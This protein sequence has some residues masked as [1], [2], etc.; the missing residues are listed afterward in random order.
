[1]FQF[2]HLF[3]IQRDNLGREHRAEAMPPE[4]SVSW[5]TSMPRSWSRSSTFRSDSG[6]RTCSITASRMISGRVLKHLKGLGLVMG[7]RSTGP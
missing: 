7:K 1:M 4:P 2:E 5:L 3:E 6:N